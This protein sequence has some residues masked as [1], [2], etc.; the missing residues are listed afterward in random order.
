MRSPIRVILPAVVAVLVLV[1]CSDDDPPARRQARAPET[2][3]APVTPVVS[4][5]VPPVPEGSCPNQAEVTSNPLN[6]SSGPLIGD[7]TG[8][9][10]P[11]RIYL[12]VDQAGTP[13]CQAFVVVSEAATITA[14][15][16]GWDPSAGIA[17]PTLDRLVQIDG[18]PGAEI[19][20]NLA[21]GASTQFVGAFAVAGGT[22]E[23]LATAGDQASAGSPDLFASGGSVGHLEAV[24]CTTDGEVVLSSAIP[25]GNRYQVTRRFFTPNGATLDLNVETSRRLVVT[26]NELEDFPEFGASPFGTC[27]SA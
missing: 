12:S 15:I 9:A 14:A 25:K 8:D 7:V 6:R 4:T 10:T 19:V 3:A 16:E 13:G 5:V 24:D 1:G 2:S 26:S 11:E 22:V 27:P 21:A 23:R 18:R 20:V 17:S